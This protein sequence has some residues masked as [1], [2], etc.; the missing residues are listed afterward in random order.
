MADPARGARSHLFDRVIGALG[1]T[2]G[3][4]RSRENCTPLSG[5]ALK[6]AL[7]DIICDQSLTSDA[8]E[9]D[10]DNWQPMTFS[11]W[12]RMYLKSYCVFSYNDEVMN[13]TL[14]MRHWEQLVQ[15]SV[16]FDPDNFMNSLNV[17]VNDY[18]W[19][20][21]TFTM[22]DQSITVTFRR[23]NSDVMIR[24]PPASLYYFAAAWNKAD[25]LK[26]GLLPTTSVET[27]IGRRV[28]E[29]DVLFKKFNLEHIRSIAKNMYESAVD[30][31]DSNDISTN[32]LRLIGYMPIIVFKVNTRVVSENSWSRKE[33]VY[34][35]DAESGIMLSYTYLPATAFEAAMHEDPI[36][37]ILGQK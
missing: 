33:T 19:F 11:Q 29:Y 37:D 10:R 26:N 34:D 30:G 17:I 4:A 27:S 22:P 23:F 8:Y 1:L 7:A 35:E 5:N 12:Q 16:M 28:A 6:K 9:A 20:V 25:I 2:R 24:Q 31:S 13:L 32:I 36:P 21:E 3:P 18:G 14:F 15:Q